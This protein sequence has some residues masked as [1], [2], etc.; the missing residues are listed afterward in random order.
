VG[1]RVLFSVDAY[2]DDEFSGTIT[3]VRLEPIEESN[4]ITYTVIIK[5]ENP[6]LKLMPGLTASIS[7]YTL[8]LP[9]V[10]TLQA[11]ALRF[12]P[13]RQILRAY[14]SNFQEDD[15]TKLAEAQNPKN[16]NMLPVGMPPKFKENHPWGELS[17]NENIVWIKNGNDIRPQKI[18]I[19]ESDGVQV[20][21]IDGLAEGDE[22]VYAME[23]SDPPTRERGDEEMGEPS[24]PFMPQRQGSNRK[25]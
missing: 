11:K 4:V 20:Q 14:I 19:G 17:E 21:I 9:D 22:V 24:S 12:E 1:Q 7:A 10:L 6:D 18:V 2:P 13:D 25:K 16:S 5:A 23:L 8:E 3:Q 15:K